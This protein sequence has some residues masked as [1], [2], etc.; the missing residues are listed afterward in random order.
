M[1]TDHEC[2]ILRISEA[3]T[4]DEGIYRCSSGKVTTS[5]RLRIIRMY[6]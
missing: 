2:H 1:T 6:S 4:E 3:F 5:A